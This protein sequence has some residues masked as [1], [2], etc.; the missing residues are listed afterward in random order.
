MGTDIV[1]QLALMPGV[2]LGALSEVNM[3]A[4]RAALSLAGWDGDDIAASAS[5]DAVDA[6]IEA[7]KVALT[8][9]YG[10]L[11]GAGRVDVVID[12]TGNPNVGTRIALEAFRNGKHVVMLNVEAD[13]TIGRHLQAEAKR[14]GVVYTGAAGDE[15]AA[16]LEVIGFAQ[17][18]GFDIVAAGQG[19]E[20][21]AEVRRDAVRLRG[22]G[23]AA[24]T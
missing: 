14:A 22:R 4:A 17:S 9:D 20:Q 15:P 13:I 2:R 10:A 11:C 21:R 16:T 3:S 7:G 12:A 19:Q 5:A 23:A 8:E 24:A 1:V 18:L 6:A